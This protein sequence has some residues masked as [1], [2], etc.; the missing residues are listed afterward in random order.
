MKLGC[1]LINKD[2]YNYA[3]D[4]AKWSGQTQCPVKE[5]KNKQKLAHDNKN[6][7]SRHED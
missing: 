3:G 4:R 6:P 5:H 1:D 2:F 7:P